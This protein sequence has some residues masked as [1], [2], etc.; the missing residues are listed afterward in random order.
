MATPTTVDGA[1]TPNG[2]PH[3]TPLERDGRH[4]SFLFVMSG[5]S[6]T[7]VPSLPWSHWPLGQRRSFSVKQRSRAFLAPAFP[8]HHD[9]IPTNAKTTTHAH[10]DMRCNTSS[11]RASAAPS[12]TA[13]G[14]RLLELAHLPHDGLGRLGH[15]GRERREGVVGLRLLD[16]YSDALRVLEGDER[17]LERAL[18]AFEDAEGIR[19]GIQETQPDN[20]FSALTPKVAEASEAVVRKVSKL[21]QTLTGGGR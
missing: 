16:A 8:F 7:S 20:S 17:A 13:A 2:P 3:P 15:L 5:Q 12:P 9:L 14:E 6:F 11:L 19:I 4:G 1:R 21:Q 10:A 18:I